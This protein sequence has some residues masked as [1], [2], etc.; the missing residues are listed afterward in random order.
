MVSWEHIRDQ[1]H[2]HSPPQCLWHK[3]PFAVKTHLTSLKSYD[4][5]LPMR[6]PVFLSKLP[7]D[8]K[9]VTGETAAPLESISFLPAH[10]LG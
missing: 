7:A 1:T 8:S 4:A 3:K 10:P 6:Q 9:H 2:R 5:V